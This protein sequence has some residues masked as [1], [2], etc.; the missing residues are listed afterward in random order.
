[1][2]T[3]SHCNGFR[4]RKLCERLDCASEPRE[5]VAR[6]ANGGNQSAEKSDHHRAGQKNR[7]RYER[8]DGFLRRAEACAARERNMSDPAAA[9]RKSLPS[10]EPMESEEKGFGEQLS[11]ER[12]AR[13][14]QGKADGDFML[15]LCRASQK[16]S[17]DIRAGDEKEQ[18]DRAE[19]QPERAARG[20]NCDFLER[21]DVHGEVGVCLRKLAAELRLDNGKVC[22]PLLESDARFKAP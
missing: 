4:P 18:R 2:P 3:S 5:T 17:D 14:A 15:S 1:M 9:A 7:E 10:V 19:E 22:A 16:Q 21:L 12:A 11:N 6:A 13:C 8:R 20:S